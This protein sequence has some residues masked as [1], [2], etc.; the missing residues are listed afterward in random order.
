ML[1]MDVMTKGIPEISLDVP[2]AGERSRM[3][4]AS[5]GEVFGAVERDSDWALDKRNPRNWPS[6]KKWAAVSV[7]SSIIVAHWVFG[8]TIECISSPHDR[9]QSIPSP[10]PLSAL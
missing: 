7:V 8:R 10:P 6:G 2:L 4:L 3:V 1:D 5:K 9:S